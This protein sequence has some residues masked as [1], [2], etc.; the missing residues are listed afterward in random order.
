MEFDG[1]EAELAGE[2]D[3]GVGGVDEGGD[4]D[5]NGL[6]ALQ[7]GGNAVGVAGEVEA[8]FGGDFLAAF[9]D[10]GGLVGKGL[11]GD[12]DD[13]GDDAH[14]EVELALDGVRGESWTSRSLMW[15]RSSRRWTVMPSAPPSSALHGGP[16]GVGLVGAAGLAQRGNVVD[17]DAQFNHGRRDCRG[18]GVFP[19][20]KFPPAGLLD[21]GE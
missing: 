14:L 16:E 8:V 9:G 11:D 2:F 4:E 18:V 19:Q 3:L 15:R 13:L 17:V 20:E 10:E 7:D 12:F 1:V 5:A 6:E 21:A